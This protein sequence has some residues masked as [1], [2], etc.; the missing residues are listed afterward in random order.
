MKKM[1]SVC[2]NGLR[3]DGISPVNFRA[4]SAAM[5]KKQECG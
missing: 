5:K 1:I 3:K 2:Q 4:V